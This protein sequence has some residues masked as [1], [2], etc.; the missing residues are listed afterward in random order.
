MSVGG[1]ESG[2]LA[3]LKAT[4]RER[5]GVWIGLMVFGFMARTGKTVKVLS[6]KCTTK[7]APSRSERDDL[8]ITE[9][10]KSNGWRLIANAALTR[11][12]GKYKYKAWKSST[13]GNSSSGNE[14]W[15]MISASGT[16]G[17]AC[18]C[19]RRPKPR[20]DAG[21]CWPRR[22]RFFSKWSDKRHRTITNSSAPLFPSAD[23]P[24]SAV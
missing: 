15:V 6:R 3:K 7:W 23:Q 8:H 16:A 20:R 12:S 17:I 1:E 10:L 13:A 11:L 21:R 14:K 18:V 24:I 4:S 5:D 19:I 22:Q 9:S 2:G